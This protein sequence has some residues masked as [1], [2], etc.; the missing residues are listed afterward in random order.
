MKASTS[1]RPTTTI[2]AISAP[3]RA[4]GR[5]EGRQWLGRTREIRLGR[6]GGRGGVVGEAR[7]PRK[8]ALAS[9]TFTAGTASRGP[10]QGQGSIRAAARNASRGDSC[11]RL[12]LAGGLPT[13]RVDS[14]LGARG[15][16]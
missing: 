6:E 5:R 11:L 10:D 2:T 15:G 4:P 8:Y 9:P 14:F 3:L 16:R 1:S 7:A 12:A 13:I